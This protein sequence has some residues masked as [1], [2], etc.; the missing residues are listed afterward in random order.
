MK[1][2]NRNSPACFDE[3]T[4]FVALHD[5]WSTTHL[6]SPR[7]KGKVVPSSS[8]TSIFTRISGIPQFIFF[9]VV[10]LRYGCE[11]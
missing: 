8:S 9:E 1:M 10:M 5:T 4:S 6:M 11:G 3:H 7:S 2:Q